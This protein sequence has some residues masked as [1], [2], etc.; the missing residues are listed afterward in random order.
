MTKS[1]DELSDVT[2]HN[3]RTHLRG[4]RAANVELRPWIQNFAVCQ[5][6]SQYQIV[7]VGIQETMAP[8]KVVRS[9]QTTTYFLACY[10]GKGLVL[11]DGRWRV[12]RAG[13]ACL[14][15][16]HT[17]NAFE[18]I[19]RS[20]WQFCWVCYQ[21]PDEQRPIGDL[22]SPVMARFDP[23]PLQSA[24]LGLIY[25]CNGPGQP[26]LIQEWSDLIHAYV[27]R[28]AH[29][30]DQP[31]QLRMLWER[32]A[33]HLA[34]EWSLAKLAREAGYSNEHLRRLC[35][36]QLGR[37]P[38]HQ[39]TYLRMRRAAELLA[40]TQLTIEAITHEIGYHNPFVFSNAFT[41]WIGWRPSEY[42]RKKMAAV[43]SESRSGEAGR[44][45]PGDLR[46]ARAKSLFAK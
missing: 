38:M 11:I 40:S 36:R 7:H 23:L 34:D 8:M 27:L 25:E 4:V 30:K 28:F 29:P 24:I 37:S 26:T 15:P 44:G 31:D 41:K 12:C 45:G 21:R 17:L 43:D 2:I 9:K 16:A 10:G 32:V 39:V 1:H 42:R 33:A 5:A 22:T 13:F 14:L 6:L 46:T 35:R 3:P 19:P 18:A 20:R